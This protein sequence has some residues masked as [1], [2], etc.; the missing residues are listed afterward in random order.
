M[1][2]SSLKTVAWASGTFCALYNNGVWER[3]TVCNVSANNLAEVLRCDFGN[4][5]KLHV[6]NLRPLLP[7]L[8]GSLLLECCLSGIRP[9][10]GSG[11][12][13]TACDF[14]AG[15][16]TGVNAVMSIQELSP[17]CPA[18]VCLVY[19]DQ[20]GQE[21]S[22]ADFLVSMGLALKERINRLNPELKVNEGLPVSEVKEAGSPREEKR[23]ASTPPPKL[24]KQ[25]YL[26]PELP[27]LGRTSLT[28]TAIGD[29][30]VIYTM[31]SAA[32]HL[33]QSL[34]ECL[35]QQMISLPS[36]KHYNWRSVQGCVVMGTDMLWYRGQV[37]DYFGGHVRVRYVDLGL[38]ENIP[39]CHVY[40][41]VL[42]EDVPQLCVPCRIGGVIP[43]AGQWH[44][45]ALALLH[46]LLLGRCVDVQILELPVEPHERVVMEIFFDDIPSASALDDLDLTVFSL[47][48]LPYKGKRFPV[49][50]KHVR[51]PNQV[52]LCSLG[53]REENASLEEAMTLV[54][55][56]IASLPHL[57]DFPFE[58]P[59]LAQYSD[60]SYYRAKLIGFAA[61]SPEVRVLVQHIDFGSDDVVSTHKL[62]RL[63]ESLLH[64]RAE[65]VH[66][67]LGG[68]K[69]PDEYAGGDCISYAPEWSMSALLMMID[70]FH[71]NLTAEVTASEPE[72]T[73]F[74]Y[75]ASG[76]LVHLPLIENGLAYYA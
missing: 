62:L 28:V 73:V 30:G 8:V 17:A 13:G 11:W 74:L 16:L 60:G 52:F 20:A 7:E 38:V 25:V 10:G 68:F 9:A 71:E 59:C 5:I 49:R 31:S 37:L 34:K 22:I 40:P 36:Q 43:V 66:V 18:C 51:T 21:V 72:P 70:L 48:P 67:R 50:I 76:A 57:T 54:N 61:V 56:D 35:Q 41:V 2:R 24:Q 63:P 29:N 46:E 4:T 42:C 69:A 6:D 15:V 39:V 44:L 55:Q 58:G 27:H 53:N 12:T 45:D 47:T 14:I 75:N 65:A 3:G 23:H 64:F 32:K 33:F 1:I 19:L 26:P